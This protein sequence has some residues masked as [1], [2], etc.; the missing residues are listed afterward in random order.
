MKVEKHED[1]IELI[2]EN[3]FERDC[4]KHI[5]G[6]RITAQW[7]NSWEPQSNLKIEFP[8]DEWGR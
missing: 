5:I 1:G 6:K 4:L 8:K 2:P 3:E 7:V